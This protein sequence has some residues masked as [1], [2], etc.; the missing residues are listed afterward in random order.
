[1]GTYYADTGGN[2]LNSGSS[3]NA[4]PDLSGTS[5]SAAANV[6]TLDAGTVLTGVVTSGANQSAI[7]IQGAT[8][9]NRTI[10]PISA[11]AGSGGASPTVTV[12]AT[13]TGVL[14]TWRIGGQYLWP[15]GAGVNVLE[16]ALG[17]GDNSAPDVLI[18]NQTPASKTVTYLTSRVAGNSTKGQ[19]IIKGKTGVRPLL[20]VTNTS[21]VLTLTNNYWRVENLEI[22]QQGASGN[23]LSMGGVS[24]V[25]YNVKVSDGGAV[26]LSMG[27]NGSRAILCEAT[28][29]LTIGIGGGATD[30]V[31]FGCYSH[32]NGTDGYAYSA[33]TS[34]GVT[35]FCI[36]D[37]NTGRG[38]HV[39]GA[40]T[41][42]TSN[43][44][45]FYNLTAYLNGDSGFRV[46]DADA[47]I[48]LWNSIFAKNGQTAAKYNIEWVAGT[49]EL[50][51]E[52]GYNC[53]Y[54]DGTG[55]SANLLN[56][57]ANSTEV[58]TDP[59]MTAPVSGDF[60]L[61]SSSPCKATGFPG[62]LLGTNLGYMD[63]GAVQRQESG[64]AASIMVGAGLTGG[65]RG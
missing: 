5:A 59:L 42:G 6:I 41:S 51:S 64:G 60:S 56:F 20:L 45:I 2:A 65:M 43:T 31:Y 15:S 30:N 24:N 46:A 53:M 52:H 29:V 8:N 14:T 3:D 35:A 9:S 49:G 11:V 10:F 32:D 39:S 33:T 12:D 63:M 44:N 1:M 23:A 17:L 55:G 19:V 57:T 54:S 40:T 47:N 18:F 4:S 58:T 13:V 61:G 38:F 27:G 34:R 26:G 62:Q 22:Q 16:G 7:N 21:V 25:A 50:L 28:G 48:S 37:T 36:A